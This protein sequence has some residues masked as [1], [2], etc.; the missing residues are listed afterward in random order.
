MRALIVLLAIMTILGAMCMAEDCLD[1]EKDMCGV[2]HGNNTNMDANG[3][4][5]ETVDR[6]CENL[7]F[8]V[9]DACGI[10]GGENRNLDID[11]NCCD[12]SERKCDTRCIS[13]AVVDGCGIC[14]GKNAT[15]DAKG[16]CCEPEDRGCDQL[17]GNAKNDKCGV[18]K[19]DGS[20]CCGPRGECSGNGECLEEYRGC[21]CNPGSTGKICEMEQDLC[22]ALDCGMYGSCSDT[23]RVAQCVCATGW[24]GSRCQFK[25]C[26][27]RGAYDTSL[28]KCKCLPGFDNSTDCRTCHPAPNGNEA[29][30]V[31]TDV[32][33]RRVFVSASIVATLSGVEKIQYRGHSAGLSWPDDYYDGVFFD[34]GCIPV[35][36]YVEAPPEDS[37][38]SA[39]V[40][41]SRYSI[42]DADEALNRLLIGAPVSFAVQ[43]SDELDQ[44]VDDTI[45]V[46]KRSAYYPALFYLG[47]GLIIVL[48]VLG[49]LTS[50][51]VVVP[52]TVRPLIARFGGSLLSKLKRKDEEIQ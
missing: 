26:S 31:H 50:F 45:L 41:I 40:Q 7:C 15:M 49:L 24:F 19:G 6:G 38:A 36:N 37:D 29:V 28:E 52:R 32:G 39:P 46:V 20:T 33:T 51:A 16:N 12:A 43:T 27:G 34:C 30:C 2:C 23:E 3:V 47:M 9:W 5:C 1:D 4:C 35:I 44:M 21:I 14:N 13:D 22:K 18:C 25:D 17:C 48:V 42:F 8:K 11:G 10:C